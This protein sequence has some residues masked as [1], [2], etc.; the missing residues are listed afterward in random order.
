MFAL[1]VP[2]RA[3]PWLSEPSLSKH[4]GLPKLDGIAVH[5]VF[6]DLTPALHCLLG[7]VM[8]MAAEALK[9]VGI[10]EQILIA[11]MLLDMVN[12]LGGSHLFGCEA[13]AA[14]GFLHQLLFSEVEPA[15]SLV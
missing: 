2:S 8:M 13:E 14:Q 10:E 12:D 1:K 15:L 11:L 7:T 4:P 5:A 6:D 9:I 3:A